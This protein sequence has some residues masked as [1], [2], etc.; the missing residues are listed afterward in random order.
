[1]TINGYNGFWLG[2]IRDHVNGTVMLINNHQPLDEIDVGS[3]V[4]HGSLLCS[5]N[6]PTEN[7]GPSAGGPST[8]TGQ[9]TCH[10]T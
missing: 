9:D 7:T 1:V 5:G 10:G 6:V 3:N 8:V 2:F 4:V